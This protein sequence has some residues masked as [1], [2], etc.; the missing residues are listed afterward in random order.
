MDWDASKLVM[1]GQNG[2]S[3]EVVQDQNRKKNA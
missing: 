2:S 3:A 1:A